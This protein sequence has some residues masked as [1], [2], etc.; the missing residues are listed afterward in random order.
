[1]QPAS[2]PGPAVQWE[3][4]LRRKARPSFPPRRLLAARCLAQL[5]AISLPWQ[6]S[7][8]HAGVQALVYVASLLFHLLLAA[9]WPAFGQA[10]I[11]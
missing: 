3:E 2:L 5:S 4:Q 6:V 8:I 1:M 11:Q 10:K 7:I 9:F